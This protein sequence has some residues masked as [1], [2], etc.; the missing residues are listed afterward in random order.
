MAKRT[1][2]IVVNSI[3]VRTHAVR[4]G[5]DSRKL[6]TITNAVEPASPSSQ[7]RGQLLDHLNLP[8]DTRLLGTAGPLA[9]TK[10]LKHMI[11]VAD[12]FK[13][14]HEPVHILIMGDG[15]HR[16]R[17]ERF[18]RQI[19]IEERV[20]FLGHRH[21]VLDILPHLDVYLSASQHEGCPNGLLE[22][23]AAGV[24]AVVTNIPG[25]RDVV[26][27]GESGFLVP[28]GSR[29]DVAKH[30]KKLLED[31]ELASRIGQAG[32]A[33]VLENHRLANVIEQYRALYERNAH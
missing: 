26:R 18:A 23:M 29:A 31:A 12:I 7:S 21:D 17:L 11:W 10:N 9:R 15:L 24:P 20:H 33:R 2:A 30:S 4:H 3:G 28:V 25:H 22:A 16:W 32:Q 8:P 27:H 14:I 6:T 19:E 13:A 1:D 5:I